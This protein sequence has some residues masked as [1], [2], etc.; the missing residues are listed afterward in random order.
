MRRPSERDVVV[1]VVGLLL[2]VVPWFGSDFFVDFVLTRVLMLG[3]VAS[4][5]VFLS[6]YGGM[7]SLAQW[8]LFGV[9]GFVVGN[10][11]G[12]SGRGLRLGFPAWPSALVAVA[13]CTALAAVL[14]LLAARTANIQYLMLTL[15]FAVIG[16]FFFGQVTTF[17]GFGGMT[18][19]DPPSLFVDRPRRLYYAALLLSAATYALLRYLAKSPFGI[20]VQGIRDDPVRMTSLGFNVAHLRVMAFTI[21][22]FIAGVAGLLNIWWN[23]QIDPTSI[24]IG[25]TL[26]LLIIAVIGGTLHLEGA[27]LGALIYLCA[28]VYLRDIPGLDSVGGVIAE[29]V[30]AEERFNTVIGIILLAIMVGSPDGA[31]GLLLRARRLLPVLNIAGSQSRQL[32]DL[33]VNNK[34]T[35]GEEK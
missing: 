12:V 33:Q 27:W 3:M 9:A 20:A 34:P 15:T 16:F 25:P 21:A 4:S 1:A 24:G 30:L 31:T 29:R 32:G 13:I 14:G 17:S 19:I 11:V 6:A 10:M 7:V 8:L 18:G 26:D 22:G 28:N 35:Q 5:L 2:C 23:G